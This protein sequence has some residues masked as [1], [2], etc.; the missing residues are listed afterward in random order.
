MCKLRIRFRIRSR[1]NQPFGVWWD[2]QGGGNCVLP[3]SFRSSFYMAITVFGEIESSMLRER[4]IGDSFCEVL[5]CQGFNGR[6]WDKFGEDL[7][8]NLSDTLVI[9]A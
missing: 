5:F 2:G 8:R 4:Y 3:A 6:L 7:S 1:L 9:V